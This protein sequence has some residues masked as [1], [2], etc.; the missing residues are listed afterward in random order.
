MYK[1]VKNDKLKRMIN[2]EKR[3]LKRRDPSLKRKV[4]S[5]RENADR[6]LPERLLLQSRLT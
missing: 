5:R 6:R 2:P 3:L 4:P 1:K